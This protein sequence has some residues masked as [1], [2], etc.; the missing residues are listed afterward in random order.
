MHEEEAAG[1]SLIHVAISAEN[2]FAIGPLDFTN[3]M[4]GALLASRSCWRRHGSSSAIPRWCRAA[5][6]A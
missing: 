6:R 5:C 1:E 2:L 3:S 4:V